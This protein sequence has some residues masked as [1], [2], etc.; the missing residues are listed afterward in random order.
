MGD[1]NIV[2]VILA[3]SKLLQKPKSPSLTTPLL[4][5]ILSGLR[6]LCIIL[7]LLSTWKASMSCLKIKSAVF[8]GMTLSLRSM[9]SRVPP[10]QYS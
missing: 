10:L 6:S 9:P 5:K 8:S 1:P 4:K 3:F 7:Y 2:L